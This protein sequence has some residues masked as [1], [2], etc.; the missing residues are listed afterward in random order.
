[1]N[2]IS[3]TNKRQ[4]HIEFFRVLMMFM[5]VMSHFIYHGIRLNPEFGNFSINS[6][7]RMTD[8]L[9]LQ[10]LSVFTSTGVNCFVLISGYFL[11]EKMEIRRSVFKIWFQ[12]VFYS[13]SISLIFLILGLHD[14]TLKQL[15]CDLSPFPSGKYWFVTQY[16]GL[17]FI[18]PFLSCLAKHLNKKQMQFLLAVLLIL[19][20]RLPFGHSFTTGMSVTWFIVLFFVGGY[21]RKYD[22]PEWMK[23]N[24]SWL[25]WL[26]AFC[27]FL[28]HLSSNYLHYQISAAPFTIKSTAN[29]DLTFIMSVLLFVF[30]VNKTWDSSLINCISRL[31]PYT[32]GIYLCHEHPLLRTLLWKE[33]VPHYCFTPYFVTCILFSLIVFLLCFLIDFLREKLFQWCRINDGVKWLGR[34]LPQP[35]KS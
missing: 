27:F 18:A 29:N 26:G 34:K 6:V 24:I 19:S 15:L 23:K 13:L 14:Y 33:L 2:Q 9:A 3:S 28:I 20:F 32:F 21:I 11:I 4:N 31:A 10:L 16:I 30:F 1:M 22:V 17:I 35:F 25:V 5:I 12:T 7:S 8:Y